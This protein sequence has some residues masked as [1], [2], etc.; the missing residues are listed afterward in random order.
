[1]KIFL[2]CLGLVG[3][4]ISGLAVL[5]MFVLRALREIDQNPH[6]PAPAP[7]WKEGYDD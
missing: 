2:M 3:V 6:G 1:M 7:Q 5:A 4:I